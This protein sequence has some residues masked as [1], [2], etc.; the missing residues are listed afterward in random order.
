MRPA[1]LWSMGQLHHG[2]LDLLESHKM[3]QMA[4]VVDS[5]VG[6]AIG[7]IVE[8]GSTASSMAARL[9]PPAKLV[10][11]RDRLSPD[12]FVDRCACPHAFMR[13]YVYS[14]LCG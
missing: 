14:C 3:L 6:H 5:R 4:G 1:L 9:D 2:L 10:P 8:H 12:P 7:V 11:H 13:A